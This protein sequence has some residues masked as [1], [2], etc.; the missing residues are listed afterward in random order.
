MPRSFV[1]I[2]IDTPSL[3]ENDCYRTMGRDSTLDGLI[4]AA[5][6]DAETRRCLMIP[7]LP[8]GGTG[9]AVPS[10]V[11]RGVAAGFSMRI[12]GHTPKNAI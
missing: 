7:S 10:F 8:D 11:V 6:N 3:E 12:L 2:T 9:S 5:R 4:T 1:F